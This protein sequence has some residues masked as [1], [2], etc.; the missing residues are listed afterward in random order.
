MSPADATAERRHDVGKFDIELLRM[1]GRFRPLDSCGSGALA[2]RTLIEMFVRLDGD[3][4]QPSAS[5]ELLIGQRQCGRC[6][7][8]LSIRLFELGLVGTRSDHEQKAT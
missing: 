2:L 1:D 7:L 5:L 8:E 4:V 3:T 6:R